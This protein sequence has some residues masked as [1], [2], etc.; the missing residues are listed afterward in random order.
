MRVAAICTWGPID[1]DMKQCWKQLQA[2]TQWCEWA[3]AQRF[4][5]IQTLR[6]HEIPHLFL[7]EDSHLSRP[8]VRMTDLDVSEEKQKL[9]FSYGQAQIQFEAFK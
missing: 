7:L 4:R 6:V 3:G 1:E 8:A 9:S 5:W 2:Q